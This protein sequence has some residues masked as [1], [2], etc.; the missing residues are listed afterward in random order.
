MLSAS[1]LRQRRH[2]RLKISVHEDE[3][4][5]AEKAAELEGI[6]LSRWARARL[7]GAEGSVSHLLGGLTE[8]QERSQLIVLLAL[9]ATR[10]D[11]LSADAVDRSG[12]RDAADILRAHR[13]EIVDALNRLFDGYDRD[14][15][16][17]R[18][19]QATVDTEPTS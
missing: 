8:G 4:L 18:R 16:D 15:A 9:I 7:F 10:L 1:S 2:L 17:D 19:A 14:E 5:A 11:S 6:S 12:A 3:K 13:D